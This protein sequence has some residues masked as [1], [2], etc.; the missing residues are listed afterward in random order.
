MQFGFYPIWTLLGTGG[1]LNSLINLVSIGILIVEAALNL[2]NILSSF[3]YKPGQVFLE[4]DL[5]LPYVLIDSLSAM[6]L[7]SH[8]S[9]FGT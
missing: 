3:R 7:A 9:T 5:I 1:H 4:K 8:K 2:S 6:H